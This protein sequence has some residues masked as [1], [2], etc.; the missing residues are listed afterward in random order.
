MYEY[1]VPG[2]YN[3]HVFI[4]TRREADAK[5]VFENCRKHQNFHLF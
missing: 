5:Y 3:L 4:F 2:T 1:D